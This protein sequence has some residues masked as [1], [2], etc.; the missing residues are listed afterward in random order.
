MID[1]LICGGFTMRQNRT[2]ALPDCNTCVCVY[3]SN[4]DSKL[5]NGVTAFY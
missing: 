1:E 3:S 5:L 2:L 4:V